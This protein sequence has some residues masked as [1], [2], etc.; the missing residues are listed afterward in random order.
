MRRGGTCRKKMYKEKAGNW[1][2]RRNCTG[3]I[4][5]PTFHERW[6]AK[7]SYSVVAAHG[8]HFYIHSCPA[9]ES[10]AGHTLRMWLCYR[11]K[12]QL[13]Q[14]QASWRLCSVVA[15]RAHQVEWRPRMCRGRLSSNCLALAES[16][17]SRQGQI[18]QSSVLPSAASQICFAKVRLEHSVPHDHGPW[19]SRESSLVRILSCQ[20]CKMEPDQNPQEAVKTQV[21]VHPGPSK[22]C[23]SM[24]LSASRRTEPWC[25]LIVTVISQYWKCA[26]LEIQQPLRFSKL[27]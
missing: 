9:T 21:S 1:F 18:P 3:Y 12:C 17:S 2:W 23:S 25:Q 4:W 6:Y 19:Y 14:P 7:A 26:D 10:A 16:N 22:E 24:Q 8:R 13:G 11:E 27:A 20:K 5:T 15:C